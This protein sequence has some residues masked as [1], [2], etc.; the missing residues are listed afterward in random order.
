MTL[1]HEKIIWSF[2]RKIM[3]F[4]GWAAMNQINSDNFSFQEIVKEEMI[5][6]QNESPTSSPIEGAPEV[7]H[8]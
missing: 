5:P 4:F 1:G 6:D 2:S 8:Q 3:N 7:S